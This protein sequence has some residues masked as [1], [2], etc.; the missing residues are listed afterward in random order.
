MSLR[1][2]SDGK[3]SDRRN[4]PWSDLISIGYVSSVTRFLK[5]PPFK[6]VKAALEAQEAGWEAMRQ[7]AP[8]A[9]EAA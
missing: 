4:V 2:S 9:P 1:K 6:E 3:S 8:V 7:G 5:V